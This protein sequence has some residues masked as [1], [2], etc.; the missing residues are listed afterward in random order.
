MFKNFHLY[1]SPEVPPSGGLPTPGAGG[2]GDIDDEDAQDA[3]DLEDDPPAGERPAGKG[4]EKTQEEIDAE[5]EERDKADLGDGDDE[6]DEEEETDEEREAREAREAEE[7]EHPP[8]GEVKTATFSDI[9]KKYPNIFKEFPQLRSALFLAPKYQEIF[10]DPESAAEAAGKSQEYDVLE[11]SLSGRGDPGPLLNTLAENNPKALKKIAENFGEAL[12]TASPDDYT[13]LT[14]PIIEE[15]L[16]HA[17]RHA[18][19][20]GDKNLLLASRHLA[21]YVFANGGEIPDISRRSAKPQPS[22]AERQL[23]QERAGYAAR[24]ENRA[25]V[26]ISKDAHSELGKVI[27]AKL[28]GL[29]DF[30]KKAIIKET[31]LEVDRTL[32]AD[33]AFQNSITALWKRAADSNYSDDSKSRIKR[34]WLDRAKL[35]APAIRNRLR[36]EALDARNPSRGNRGEADR[37]KPAEG[38][39]KRSFPSGG[40]NRGES[41]SGF[42]DPKKI[43]WN[44]T[45]DMDILK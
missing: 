36:Q 35:V 38:Q 8:E 23:Q 32:K 41:R 7:E 27:T 1:L 11:E 3:R 30:E 19:K 42:A 25:L 31:R 22:E 5:I 24:E 39:K 29:S 43:D 17:S 37:E 14:T 2:I 13:T 20:V 15:L 6:E 10:S 16:F 12:R 40:G 34:A 26:D 45:S 9:K 28:D 33:R 4:K 21:N 18:N 44:K